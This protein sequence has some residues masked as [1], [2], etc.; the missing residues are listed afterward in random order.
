M[1]GANAEH[2]YL[3]FYLRYISRSLAFTVLLSKIYLQVPGLKHD[4]SS[5]LATHRAR[6]YHAA[7]K[8]VVESMEIS[9]K[10]GAVLDCKHKGKIIEVTG[11]PCVGCFSMDLEEKY[12]VS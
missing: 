6:V 10:Y 4:D 8:K 3:R 1:Q 12:V 7:A 5:H 11:H 2:F 9:A